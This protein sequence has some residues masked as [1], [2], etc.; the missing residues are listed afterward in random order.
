MK[1]PNSET[2]LHEVNLEKSGIQYHNSIGTGERYH[3]PL[4]DT[5]RKLKI[6]H[7]KM[8]PQLLFALA[9]KAMNDTPGS[10]GTVPS[11]LVFSEFPSLRSFEDR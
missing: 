1:V 8:Q 9:V 10:E 6:D 7:P 11:G 4:R 3:K 2:A 5:F